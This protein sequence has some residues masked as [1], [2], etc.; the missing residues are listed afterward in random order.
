MHAVWKGFEG[1]SYLG[2]ALR[3]GYV[4]W[5]EEQL[6]D[7]AGVVAQA[8]VA[9][10]EVGAGEAGGD[11]GG[12]AQ[13]E[14]GMGVFQG[15]HAAVAVRGAGADDS[16]AGSDEDRVP[17]QLVGGGIQGAHRA[18]R[19]VFAAVGRRCGDVAV[20]EAAFAQLLHV[21]G[22]GAGQCAAARLHVADPQ[23]WRRLRKCPGR[24]CEV[25]MER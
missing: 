8:L 16:R 15:C 23:P 25:P 19:L 4:D 2:L 17:A 7:G 5:G 21:A 18:D 6:E 14:N 12:E 20:E 22:E 13:G 1:G 11:Q 3:D 9:V 10:A 24:R